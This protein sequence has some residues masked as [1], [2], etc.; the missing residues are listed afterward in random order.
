MRLKERDDDATGGSFRT[1]DMPRTAPLAAGYVAF[2]REGSP[3]Y[4]AADA[5]TRGTLFPGL[6]LPFMNVTNK[7]N[8]YA[9]TP[10]GE[11]MAIEFAVHELTLYLDTHGGDREA[12]ALMKKLLALNKEGRE[13][14]ARAYGPLVTGELALQ[15]SFNWASQPWPWDMDERTGK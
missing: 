7:G 6:D 15:E 9:G 8:P 14:Y 12:F 5:L 13:R 3:K 4:D 11:L 1:G 2:Q 10:L